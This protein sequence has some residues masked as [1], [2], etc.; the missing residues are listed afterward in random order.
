[1]PLSKISTIA[2]RVLAG[3]TVSLITAFGKQALADGATQPTGAAECDMQAFMDLDGLFR[4]MGSGID[5]EMMIG[6][7]GFD[8]LKRIR[9]YPAV[10][11]NEVFQASPEYRE[12]LG[13]FE[14]YVNGPLDDTN[15][16]PEYKCGNWV[17]ERLVGLEKHHQVGE[18][19]FAYALAAL[20][21]HDLDE[22]L[23][24]FEFISRYANDPDVD[25]FIHRDDVNRDRMGLGGTLASALEAMKKTEKGAC[26]NSNF[27]IKDSSVLEVLIEKLMEE[28]NPIRAEDLIREQ[29]SMFKY[30]KDSDIKKIAS[31]P[32]KLDRLQ[33]LFET[34][35][36]DRALYP[37]S[38]FHTMHRI[39]KDADGS[40]AHIIDLIDSTIDQ[41]K[42]IAIDYQARAFGGTF[43]QTGIKTKSRSLPSSRA[44]HVSTV[45][46]RRFKNNRCEYLV[47]DSVAVSCD[48]VAQ[49]YDCDKKTGNIWVPRTTLYNSVLSI[50]RLESAPGLSPSAS[51]STRVK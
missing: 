26:L 31:Q 34:S 28:S 15:D 4:P 11:L 20:A 48:Q 25:D 30:L 22:D 37:F 46:G 19:C 9:R 14:A 3:L 18:N 51:G 12:K 33:K 44:D 38:T 35:C 36:R 40:P 27:E 39:D 32:R 47:R 21:S 16:I 45:I 5:Y 10:C 1:M 42:P 29:R 8:L 6:K 17:S 7:D 2:R 24:P 23:S 50:E 41:K 13:N 43:L 49:S